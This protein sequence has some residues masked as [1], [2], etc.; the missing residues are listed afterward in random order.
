[1][2]ARLCLVKTWLGNTETRVRLPFVLAGLLELP[3]P[4]SSIK[5]KGRRPSRE[6]RL[7]HQNKNITRMSKAR[8]PVEAPE[9]DLSIGDTLGTIALLT[10]NGA[11][12]RRGGMAGASI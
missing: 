7:C 1:M 6:A 12:R 4:G 10:N 2:D 8:N 3:I 5:L 9:S 11:N